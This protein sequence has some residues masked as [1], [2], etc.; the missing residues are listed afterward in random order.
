MSNSGKEGLSELQFLNNVGYQV[1][2]LGMMEKSI[3][4][5]KKQKHINLVVLYKL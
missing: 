5:V 3:P 4:L 1:Q 2:N